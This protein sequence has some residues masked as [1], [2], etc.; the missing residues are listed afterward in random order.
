MEIQLEDFVSESLNQIIKA[1]IKSQKYAE[2][3]DAKIN[4]AIEL[5]EIKGEN[6]FRDS[7]MKYGQ[8]IE[9]D[10]AVSASK[11]KN[12]NE[13]NG[14]SVIQIG[15]SKIWNK[16]ISESKISRIKFSIPIVLPQQVN[17]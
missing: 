8:F 2:T 11:G 1:V 5:R 10:I 6:Y 3:V 16:S 13:K 15:L 7:T 9:F 12:E 4:P 14:V 17:K